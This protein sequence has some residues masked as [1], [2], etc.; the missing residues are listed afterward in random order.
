MIRDFSE[1]KKK[2]LYETLEIVDNKEWKPFMEWCGGRT[3]EFG[4]LADKLGISSYTRQIDSY[5]N[6]I[7][8]TNNSIRNQIDVIFENV[9]ETD[10]RFAEF[11]RECA[12]IVKEQVARIRLMVEVMKLAYEIG[13]D[14]V[15]MLFEMEQNSVNQREEMSLKGRKILLRWL[16]SKK[17]ID[18]SEW[19]KLCD[20]IMENQSDMLINMYITNCYS[21]TDTKK[22][23]AA[24][25]DYYNKHKMDISIDDVKDLDL[26]EGMDQIQKETFVACWNMLGQM[27]LSKEQIIAVMAN[28]Y[29]ESRFSATNAQESYGYTGLYDEYEFKE[30]DGVGY[31]ICQWTLESRKEQLL[32]YANNTGGSVYNLDTQLNYFKYEMEEGICAGYWENF[33]SKETTYDAMYYF[34]DQIENSQMNNTEERWAYATA[35]ETWSSELE[36]R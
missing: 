28:I 16:K 22:V 21:S 17:D 14:N 31:G 24:I 7:L 34:M 5:Q 10:H 25:K 15:N 23:Y 1:E 8:D 4:V 2:E 12:E 27:E 6:R 33:L 9:A 3:S 26:G 30:D 29:A 20:I 13:L 19:E 36:L 11:L 18:P 35:I 32:E